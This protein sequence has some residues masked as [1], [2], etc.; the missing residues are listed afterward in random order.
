PGD[1]LAR[2]GNLTYV[3]NRNRPNVDRFFDAMR[4]RAS[5]I[6][7]LLIRSVNHR[8]CRRL[9]LS[10]STDPGAVDWP[11]RIGAAA[12]DRYAVPH[13]VSGDKALAGQDAWMTALVGVRNEVSDLLDG[14]AIANTDAPTALPPASVESLVDAYAQAAGRRAATRSDDEE[15]LLNAWRESQERVVDFQARGSSL[16]LTSTGDLAGRISQIGAYLGSGLCRCASMILPYFY[17]THYGDESHPKALD[18]AFGAM[19]AIDRLLQQTPGTNAPTLADE[20][21]VVVYSEM[22]RT[23]YLTVA[24]GREHW[25]FTSCVLWGPGV[26]GG[27]QIGGYDDDM[28]G[29]PVDLASGRTSPDHGVQLAPDVVGSTLLRVAGV[30]PAASLGADTSVTALLADA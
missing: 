7:G 22:G 30:D 27:Q 18:G 26:R 19:M 11:T 24:D 15:M 8:T 10:N 21:V 6:D 23:P 25:M 1:E 4:D 28:V 12:R 17:D 20:T 16:D 9:W 14:A 2:A 3:A 13:I 5:T 29:I